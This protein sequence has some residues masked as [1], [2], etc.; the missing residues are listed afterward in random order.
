MDD[1]LLFADNPST[2][3]TWRTEIYK[4][5]ER[6]RLRLHPAQ[7]YPTATGIPFLGF[8]IFPT[9]RRLKR[10]K[11]VAFVRRF[12]R[13]YQMWLVN[14]VPRNRLDASARSWAAHASWGDTYHLRQAVLG[15]FLL[16]QQ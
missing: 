9:Q 3:A 15:Q 4:R 1:F 14:D 5:L 7:V 10:R 16:R 8:R 2:L 6:F 11:G 12:R 13:L